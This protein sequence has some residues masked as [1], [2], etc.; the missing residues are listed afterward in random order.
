MRHKLFD[1]DSVERKSSSVSSPPRRNH[2]YIRDDQQHVTELRDHGRNKLSKNLRI[3]TKWY[4]SLRSRT[5]FL[6]HICNFLFHC[7]VCNVAFHRTRLARYMRILKVL[8]INVHNSSLRYSHY[9]SNNQTL[10][11]LDENYRVQI[12]SI[13]TFNYARYILKLSFIRESNLSDLF[14]L[15]ILS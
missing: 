12:A 8:H 5:N 9:S 14:R 4:A 3:G 15:L 13:F 1:K 6:E 10:F 7:P 11:I 2:E